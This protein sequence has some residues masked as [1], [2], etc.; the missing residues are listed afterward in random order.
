MSAGDEAE[1][2]H[3]EV[4]NAKLAEKSECPFCKKNGTL[5]VAYRLEA[6]PLGTHA[7]S[8][9]QIKFSAVRELWATCSTEDC[10]FDTR[11]NVRVTDTSGES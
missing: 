7:L 1:A 4:L 9:S 2:K 5:S 10:G 11:V 8:G 6:K 3:L